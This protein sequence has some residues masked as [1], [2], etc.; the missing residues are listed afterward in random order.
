MRN[1]AED[2]LRKFVETAPWITI[3][4]PH[5]D[6]GLEC[7]YCGAPEGQE[8]GLECPYPQ[9]EKYLATEAPMGRHVP[10]LCD[11]CYHAGKRRQSFHWSATPPPKAM[12]HRAGDPVAGGLHCCTPHAEAL[13]KYHTGIKP[14]ES[15]EQP[16]V[17]RGAVA[18]R[19]RIREG[20]DR[21]TTDRLPT[22]TPAELS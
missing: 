5:D 19:E 14:G 21:A 6:I 3:S 20:S 2:L 4:G 13:Q 10:V 11:F 1:P 7:V 16:T 9:A 15:P 18:D 22:Q 12:T 8:H 17:Y